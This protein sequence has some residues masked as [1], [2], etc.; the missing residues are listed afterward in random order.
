M[1][2]CVLCVCV[3]LLIHPPINLL[4][5]W[6]YAK[7]YITVCCECAPLYIRVWVFYSACYLVLY[8]I[9]ACD[10]C[11]GAMCNGFTLPSVWQNVWLLCKIFLLLSTFMC[12][13]KSRYCYSS[14]KLNQTTVIVLLYIHGRGIV[15]L[16]E[17]CPTPL[18]KGFFQF[19]F[20]V[21]DVKN[22]NKIN[23][24]ICVDKWSH[25]TFNCDLVRRTYTISGQQEKK[26]FT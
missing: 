4:T 10:C 1:R 15:L 16:T 13:E 12:T 7:V 3:C 21:T 22:N 19:T 26:Y 5:A 8:M 17:V 25:T 20:Y 6:V 2:T 11:K 24:N 23:N 18:Q 14:M 9:G